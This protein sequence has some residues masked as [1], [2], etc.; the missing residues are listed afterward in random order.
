MFAAAAAQLPALLSAYRTGGVP[1][2][3]YGTDARES[4]G[5]LNR[6]WDEQILPGAL[7]GVPSLND[8]LPRPKARI[9]DIGRGVGWSSI[10]LARAC[11]DASVDGFDTDAASIETAQSNAA[12]AAVPD[13]VRFTSGDAAALDGAYDA[14]FAFEC[15]HD[16]PRPVEVLAAAARALT[17]QGCVVVMDEAVADSFHTPADVLERLMYG[18]SLLVCLPDG[19]ADPPSAATGTVMCPDM[20][21]SCAREAGLG[22]FEILPI[23]DSG[24]WRFYCLTR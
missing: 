23:D 2:R 3:Q 17:P 24:F 13:R 6:P 22:T 5:D 9:A 7:A 12:D 1:W 18:F 19:M 4:Q 10:A 8:V 15:V 14:V 16:M 11:P 20:L 21:R